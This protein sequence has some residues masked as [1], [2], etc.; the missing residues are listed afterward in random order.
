MVQMLPNLL[1]HQLTTTHIYG[2]YTICKPH[3][4]FSE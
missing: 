4:S 2:Q 1:H 3:D